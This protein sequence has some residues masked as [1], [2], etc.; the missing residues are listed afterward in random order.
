MVCEYVVSVGEEVVLE[1]DGITLSHGGRDIVRDVSFR[2][3]QG[4][5]TLLAGPNGSGKSTLLSIICGLRQQSSGVVSLSGERYSDMVDPVLRVGAFLS[6]EWLDAARSARENL[7]ILAQAAGIDASRVEEVIEICGLSAAADRLVK[8]FSLGMRQR[9][10]IAASLLG[11]PKFLILDEPANGL[12]PLGMAWMRDL[13]VAHRSNGG[14]V[15]L[16]SH[17]LRDAEDICDDLVV[18]AHGEVQ[19]A[20]PLAEFG[21]EA[22]VISEFAS[23]RWEEIVKVLAVDAE[24]LDGGLV[25]VPVEPRLVSE[26]ARRCGADLTYL[27]PQ[28]ESLEES[29][30]ALVS[31]KDSIR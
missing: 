8:G 13:L 10:G 27:V 29:F 24:S 7:K 21:V 31:G 12:D 30:Q 2:V 3:R 15:L 4:I 23:D 28:K 26:A 16:S 18:L 20:G 19:F 9:C 5:I 14:T 22:E 25:R 1:V 6:A 17:L 11:S